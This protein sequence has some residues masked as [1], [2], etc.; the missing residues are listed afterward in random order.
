MLARAVLDDQIFTNQNT[1]EE[2]GQ[3]RRIQICDHVPFLIHNMLVNPM[4]TVTKTSA[5]IRDALSSNQ[6]IRQSIFT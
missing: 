3:N 2:T 5:I 1:A 6:L 4:N